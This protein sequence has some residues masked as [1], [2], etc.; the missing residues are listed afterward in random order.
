[1]YLKDI[2]YATM[3]SGEIEDAALEQLKQLKKAPFELKV[4]ALDEQTSI[5]QVTAI[6]IKKGRL[7]C[8]Y[9]SSGDHVFI[10][11][12]DLTERKTRRPSVLISAKKLTPKPTNVLR[13]NKP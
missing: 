1:M 11:L 7:L 6:S 13:K 5:L 12:G 3:T 4:K 8:G 9:T 2:Q 10:K